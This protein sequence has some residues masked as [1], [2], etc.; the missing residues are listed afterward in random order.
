MLV[1]YSN[2]LTVICPF[3]V[4]GVADLMP[5]DDDMPPSQVS[6]EVLKLILDE[7]ITGAALMVNKQGTEIV[8]APTIALY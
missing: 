1:D 8:E 3:A 5:G 6:V 2:I 4:H 7:N